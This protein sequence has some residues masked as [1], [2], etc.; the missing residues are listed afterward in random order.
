MGNPSGTRKC[1]RLVHKSSGGTSG[2]S[3]VKSVLALFGYRSA[4]R[5][6]IDV[7]VDPLRNVLYTLDLDGR[8]DLFDLGA[9]GNQTT[10]KARGVIEFCDEA[11]LLGFGAESGD[12]SRFRPMFVQVLKMIVKSEDDELVPND[13]GSNMYI[14]QHRIT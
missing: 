1:E 6:L 8:M 14:A 12:T 13:F 10:Q 11:I 5:T 9:D 7:V 3:P 4:E 2:S